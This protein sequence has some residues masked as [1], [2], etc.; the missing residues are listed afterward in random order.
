MTNMCKLWKKPE[1]VDNVDHKMPL[2]GKWVWVFHLNTICLLQQAL[3]WKNTSL[4]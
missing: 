3:E 2:G 1:K 4:L